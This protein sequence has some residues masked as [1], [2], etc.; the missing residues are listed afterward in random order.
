MKNL[1][2]WARSEIIRRRTV[3][4]CSGMLEWWIV[5]ILG[6]SGMRPDFIVIARTR[7]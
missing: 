5:G 3:N 7:I 2:F 6:F 1:I 4:I